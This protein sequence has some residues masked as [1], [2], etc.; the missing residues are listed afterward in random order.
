MK[1]DGMGDIF[2]SSTF[3]IVERIEPQ[4]HG[5]KSMGEQEASIILVIISTFFRAGTHSSTGSTTSSQQYQV[6]QVN[7]ISATLPLNE[8]F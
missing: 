5:S 8:N 3:A 6:I 1:W 2:T 4:K 7:S